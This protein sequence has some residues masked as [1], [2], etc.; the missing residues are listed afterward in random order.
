MVYEHV[1]R[2]AILNDIEKGYAEIGYHPEML[3]S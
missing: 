3:K 2:V 1:N